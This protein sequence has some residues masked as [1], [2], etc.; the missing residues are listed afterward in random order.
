MDTASGYGQTVSLGGAHRGVLPFTVEYTTGSSPGMRIPDAL[1]RQGEDERQKE[2]G[3]LSAEQ[4]ELAQVIQAGRSQTGHIRFNHMTLRPPRRRRRPLYVLLL[5]S[6]RSRSVEKYLR[7]RDPFTVIYT[8]DV[9]PTASPT[10]CG[11]V[12]NWRELLGQVVLPPGQ[13]WDLIWTSPPCK[14]LSNANTSGA[15]IAPALELV[16]A[17]M[18]CIRALRPRLWILENPASGPRALHKQ[19]LM[20]A[21]EKL[22]VTTSYCWYGAW[23]RKATSFWTNFGGALRTPCTPRDLCPC[24]QSFGHHPFTAQAGPS[25]RS[26]YPQEG[27]GRVTKYVSVGYATLGTRRTNTYGNA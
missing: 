24:V 16:R 15:P 23:Y 27:M 4:P 10:L 14:L 1:S 5:C 3:P 6:G 9:D 2:W 20:Q 7:H 18:A 8:L 12:R 22:R 26:T 17:C 25:R 11:D 19:P 21:Y 13:E